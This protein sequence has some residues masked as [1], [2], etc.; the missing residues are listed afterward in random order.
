MAALCESGTFAP[1]L[2]VS[3]GV[4]EHVFRTRD[5]DAFVGT[6]L[7]DAPLVGSRGNLCDVVS[8]GKRAQTSTIEIVSALIDGSLR[9]AGRL[10][11]AS[12]I[13]Q[14]LVN[15]ENVKA[16]RSRSVDIDVARTRQAGRQKLGLTWLVFGKLVQLGYINV[17]SVGIGL[18]NRTR[19]LID[20]ANLDA[21][22]AAYVSAAEIAAEQKTH[23]RTL[24]PRLRQ[25]GIE[26]AIGRNEAGQYFY[27]RADL[28]AR[29]QPTA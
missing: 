19:E 3:T 14:V 9:C 5:L 4:K 25:E 8:A 29:Q 12:G 28:A 16:I 2:H 21:F 18:R 27:R 20:P 15:L 1:F 13:M 6:L 22:A 7:G 26:P 23:V 24:V 10:A 17:T 11:G